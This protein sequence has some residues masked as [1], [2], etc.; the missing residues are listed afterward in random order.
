MQQNAGKVRLGKGQLC[1]RDWSSAA[2][3]V[4]G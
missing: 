2:Y 4:A 3:V 1:C